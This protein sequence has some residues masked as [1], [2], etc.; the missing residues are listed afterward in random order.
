VIIQRRVFISNISDQLLLGVFI[1]ISLFIRTQGLLILATLGVAQ[2][3]EIL[4]NTRLEKG[5]VARGTSKA[6]DRFLQR[7][8]SRSSN[9]WFFILPH[10]S[11]LIVT[12][13]WRSFLPEGGTSHI[14]LFNDLSLWKIKSNILHYFN[15]PAV[16]FAGVPAAQIIYGASIPLAIIG[17]FE[18]RDS[19][20]QIIL[21]GVMTIL[22]LIVW[23]S[24]SGLR[25]FFP[26]LPFY[27]SFTLTGLV[28]FRD[29]N[30]GLWKIL[31]RILGVSPLIIICILFLRSSMMN[32]Y[33]NVVNHRTENT[34]PF[35]STSKEVFS[36][37]SNNTETDSIIVFYKPRVMRLF[38]NRRSIMINQ[39]DKL[40][41]GD[42][43]CISLSQNAYHQIGNTDLASL[44][45][46]GRIHS[47]Y[48]NK[49]FRL[50]QIKK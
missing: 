28:K 42:Y 10:V 7:F 47:V 20:Y 22:L 44:Y 29:I 38:T 46:K 2:F 16:F 41:K 5:G 48:E 39:I 12:L 27:V 34:G 50:Y 9:L 30:Q 6:S 43:L 26:L 23:P 8:F 40:T 18:R 33:G 32:S 37:I 4:K 35:L 3:I 49:D 24:P 21:Y 45:E 13:L 19:D 14:L 1:A 11:F 17:M 25:L 36:F 31:W 15:L